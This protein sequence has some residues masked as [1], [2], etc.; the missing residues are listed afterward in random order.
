MTVRISGELKPSSS[1]CSLPSLI[2]APVAGGGSLGWKVS[3]M[4]MATK[5]MWRGG[6]DSYG[7]ERRCQYQSHC[8]IDCDY[9]LIVACYC[10]MR[11]DCTARAVPLVP[12]NTY[13]CSKLSHIVAENELSKTLRISWVPTS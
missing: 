2:I 8:N 10:L 3:V 5:R 4:L 9:I 11:R 1:S 13:S 12:P 7:T 6:G